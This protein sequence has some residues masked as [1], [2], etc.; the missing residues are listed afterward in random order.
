M[1][2]LTN[3]SCSGS[4]GSLGIVTKIAILTPAKLPSTNVA[5]LSC[6]DYIS[7]QKLLLAARRSLGEILSAFEFMDRHCIN[8]VLT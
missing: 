2:T 8:L 7:C 5:F 4:E 3:S 1:N 6:N